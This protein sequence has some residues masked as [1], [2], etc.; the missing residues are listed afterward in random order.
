M[1]I[2]YY[3]VLCSLFFLIITRKK[4]E[5]KKKWGFWYK[6]NA[7]LKE[8]ERKGKTS[9]V[10]TWKNEHLANMPERLPGE[11]IIGIHWWCFRSPVVQFR[12]FAFFFFFACGFGPILYT[13][14]I[15]AFFHF[16]GPTFS[17]ISPELSRYDV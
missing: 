14:L 11:L 13:L 16:F 4:K 1:K 5:G 9:C 17:R 15:G 12:L 2:P 8:R 6:K 10:F 7:F 3:L